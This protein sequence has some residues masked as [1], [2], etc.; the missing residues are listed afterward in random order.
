MRIIVNGKLLE[1]EEDISL[2][3]LLEKNR[4]EIRPVGLAVAVNEEIVP[5]SKYEEY[6]LKEG[7]R[8]EIVNIVGGG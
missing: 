6:K 3:A 4:I 7:D 8:V 1:V 5:K 2:L